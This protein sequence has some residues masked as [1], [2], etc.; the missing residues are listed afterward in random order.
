[1]AIQVHNTYTK[2][3]H[4]EHV[5]CVVRVYS[6]M[7]EVNLSDTLDFSDYQ[8]VNCTYATVYLGRVGK[9]GQELSV[10]ERFADVNCSNHFAWRGADVRTA[11]VD[12]GA[13]ENEELVEDL[14]A[15]EGHLLGLRF[16]NAEKHAEQKSFELKEKQERIKNA[17][18]VGKKMVVVSGRKVKPGHEGTVAYVRE[19]RV[20]LK[21]H[22]EWKDRKAN[23]VWVEAR[24]LKAAG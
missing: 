4:F 7:K 5:G 3:S 17:P 24:H 16:K 20:L 6:I 8:T 14:A 15:Y 13:M 9:D 21:A 2:S 1:M 19:N 12:P 23:G 10:T 22:N 11:T 18:V